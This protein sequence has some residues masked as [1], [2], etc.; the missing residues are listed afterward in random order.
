[1]IDYILVYNAAKRVKFLSDLYLVYLMPCSMRFDYPYLSLHNFT[2]CLS[3][4]CSLRHRHSYLELRERAKVPAI[5][6]AR[7]ALCMSAGEVSVRDHI[8]LFY[9]QSRCIFFHDKLS[10]SAIQR[11]LEHVHLQHGST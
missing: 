7:K 9:L 10:L 4:S 5:L 2:I 1:M 3:P 11:L 6:R 8:L